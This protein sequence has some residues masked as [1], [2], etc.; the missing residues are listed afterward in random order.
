[1]KILIFTTA[2]NEEDTIGDILDR[3]FEVKAEIP[4]VIDVLVVDDGSQDYTS[5]IAAKR[6][7]K[8]IKHPRNLGPGIATRRG[9]YYALENGYDATVR[10][11]AD[12][13]HRP[14][15]IPKI[16]QPILNDDADI[17]IGSRYIDDVNYTTTYTRDIGIRFFS[18][19]ISLITRNRVYDITSGFRA[20]K[21]EVAEEH[22]KHLSS[23]IAAINRGIREGFGPYE[24]TE[25]PVEMD[26][27]KYGQSYLN[28]KRLIIYPIYSIY[29]LI[30]TLFHVA[31]GD[32]KCSEKE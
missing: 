18:W 6:D 29:S 16:L 12:G 1:M 2:Y 19:F 8:I 25:V 27:R 26:Q 11:D 30:I 31:R 5:T 9:Y 13:Q 21:I 14:E 4:H 23:G 10:L 22:A 32:Y 7:V 28:K 3:I 20:V 15:D 24:I 17:S